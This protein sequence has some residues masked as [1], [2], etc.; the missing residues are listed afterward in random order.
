MEA[1]NT[2]QHAPLAWQV[3][4]REWV[5]GRERDIEQKETSEQP[6]SGDK[7]LGADKTEVAAPIA[8]AALAAPSSAG[9]RTG[10]GG[11]GSGRPGRGGG[12]GGSGGGGGGGGGNGDG[13][14]G[15]EDGGGDGDGDGGGEDTV[16]ARM[17][18]ER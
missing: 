1:R 4:A 7:G 8:P 2:P 13:G 3:L 10:G 9:S 6:G 15:G 16:V 11:A 14:S 18:A 12:G 5:Q 17:V